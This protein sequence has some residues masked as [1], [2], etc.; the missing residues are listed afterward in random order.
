MN[1]SKQILL[2]INLLG[3]AAVI[4]S[5]IWGFISS[6]GGLEA[7]WGGVPAVLRTAITVNMLLAAASYLVIFLILLLRVPVAATVGNLPFWT[8]HIIYLVILFPSAL[9][10]P[11]T[12][13]VIKQYT[14]LCW[15]SVVLVL[16][17]TALAGIA[18]LIALLCLRPALTSRQK[19]L[20]IIGS[21]FFI[22]QTTILDAILWT[23]FFRN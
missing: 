6:P 3:G 2:L 4:G 15:G 7:F 13:A 20:A 8:F 17:L 12:Q 14:P 22:L 9:W 19:T 18:L 23:S 5:Y 1:K 21:A 11:L 10:M 16:V